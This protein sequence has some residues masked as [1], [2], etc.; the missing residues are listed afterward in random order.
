MHQLYKI[1][2]VFIYS[3]K[4]LRYSFSGL[5]ERHTNRKWSKEKM[6]NPGKFPSVFQFGINVGFVSQL[7]ALPVNS[8]IPKEIIIKQEAAHAFQMISG[9]F[10]IWYFLLCLNSLSM[11]Y[12]ID[13]R[14]V[15]TACRHSAKCIVYISI[16]PFSLLCSVL[17][18][19]KIKQRITFNLYNTVFYLFK[20]YMWNLEAH[21]KNYICLIH[22]SVI[23]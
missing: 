2:A 3:K 20:K 7:N 8:Q 21:F 23:G 15:T 22:F 5:E 11:C 10:T 19:K 14:N 9:L 17:S 12:G 6:K 16:S 13:S 18:K 4:Y 1:I